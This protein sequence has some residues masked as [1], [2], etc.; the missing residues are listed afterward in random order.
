MNL[1]QICKTLKAF[2]FQCLLYIEPSI[3][4]YITHDGLE[5]SESEV[6]VHLLEHKDV[7]IQSTAADLTG[8]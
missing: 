1:V 5:C 6:I 2:S 3:N 8:G 7:T 4:P